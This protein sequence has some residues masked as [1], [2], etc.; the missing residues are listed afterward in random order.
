MTTKTIGSEHKKVV[1]FYRKN[2][3]V[4]AYKGQNGSLKYA[5][6]EIAEALDA[7]IRAENPGDLRRTEKET[8][9][10]AEIGDTMFML[11]ASIGIHDDSSEIF[12]HNMRRYLGRVENGDIELSGLYSDEVTEGVDAAISRAGENIASAL[13]DN[14][15]GISFAMK[16]SNAIGAFDWRG[17][18][19]DKTIAK[20]QKRCDNKRSEFNAVG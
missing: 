16:V 14:P 20:L 5:F 4:F 19:L 18:R 10:H 7:R 13:R 9:Y 15:E 11:L 17:E 12:L 3:D 1:D 2:I 6:T 8:D